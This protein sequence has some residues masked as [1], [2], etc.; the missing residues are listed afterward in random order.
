M[1]FQNAGLREVLGRVLRIQVECVHFA[2]KLL[3]A[4]VG[5]LGLPAIL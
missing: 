2:C 4:S 3:M 1:V 5:K